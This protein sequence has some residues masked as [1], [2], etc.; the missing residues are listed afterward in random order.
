MTEHRIT[1][2]TDLLK[3]T[4]DEFGRFI[5]DLAAWFL[6]AKAF[7]SAGAENTGFVW[8]D[9][10]RPGVISRIDGVCADTGETFSIP[11]EAA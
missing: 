2:I 7:E 6:A 3:L 4:E 8:S 10:G 11:L 9:D 5:P 1:H